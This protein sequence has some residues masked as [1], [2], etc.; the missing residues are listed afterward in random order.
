[1]KK[2]LFFYS[3]MLVFF[4]F[5]TYLFVDAN[6]IYLHA[7]FTDFSSQHREV[8]TGGYLLFLALAFSLYFFIVHA[9]KNTQNQMMWFKRFVIVTICIL[10]FSYPAM[11][12]FDIFNYI[13]TAKVLF[14]YQENPYLIMPIAFVGDSLLL[15]THAPNKVALYGPFW[16]LLSGIPYFLGFG[17]FLLTLLSFKLFLAC[18]YLGSLWL[19][20]KLTKS[21]QTLTLFA[22]NPLILIETLVSA[23]NDMVMVF[24]MLLAFYFLKNKK[25]VFSFISFIGAGLIKYAAFILA[26]VIAFLSWKLLRKQ[27]VQWQ[28][29]YYYC[30]IVLLIFMVIAAPIREEIYPWYAVWFLSFAFMVPEKKNL[31]F[32]SQIISM[33]LMLRYIPFMLL[34]THFGPTPFIKIFVTFAPSFCFL[35][36]IFMKKYVWLK[37]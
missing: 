17:N 32:L 22:F 29:W 14:F 6:L 36:Y 1:M 8:V 13:F 12:S 2:L 24:F 26:P 7:L 33:S 3:F 28:K 5:F 31:L 30:S 9:F 4:T 11:L 18:F 34:G 21:I 20:W 25:I 10:V 19:L 23:H 15:F 16:I 35:L 37:K 27:E